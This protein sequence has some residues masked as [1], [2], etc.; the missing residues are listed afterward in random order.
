MDTEAQQA[1]E[2]L[3]AIEA[4]IAEIAAQLEGPNPPTGEQG[5]QLAIE[6]VRLNGQRNYLVAEF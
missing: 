3:A 4:R 2:K 6:H 1:A 5:K